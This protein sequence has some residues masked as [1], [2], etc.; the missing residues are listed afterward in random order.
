MSKGGDAPTPPDPAKTIAAQTQSNQQ[1][2][3]YQQ[4]LNFVNSNT[5]LGSLKYTKLSD[6]SDGTPPQW[7]SDVSLTDQG[8]QA[9]D[10]NQAVANALSRLALQGT[11]Q[12]S[13][14]IARPAGYDSL[15]K[16]PEGLDLSGLP[17]LASGL[18]TRGLP[19]LATGLDY[20][21]LPNAPGG[22]DLSALGDAPKFDINSGKAASDALY[23]QATSRL[24]PQYAKA[25]AAME[26]K[27]INSGLSK[28]TPAYNSAWESYNRSK[29]DAY[30]SASREATAGGANY[31][32]QLLGGQLAVRGQGVSE[33]QQ[34]LA[35]ALSLRQNAASEAQQKFSAT[36][37]SRA[38]GFGEAL[39]GFNAQ[40]SARAQG[41]GERQQSLADALQLRQQGVTESNYLRELP[42]NEV[43]ALE[44]GGQVQLPSFG[45]PAPVSVGR[46]D[47][48]GITQQ[49][50]QNQQTQYQQQQAQQQAL[51]GDVFG[52]AGAA[53]GGWGFGG[54]K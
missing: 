38:Q 22:L 20:S 12:V 28:G 8:Q 27:L 47:V 23:A 44:S 11:S 16:L 35:D 19:A 33:A 43:T 40:N 1:T 13:D 48:A 42:L 37:S 30:G 34:K 31:A 2:A 3:A 52:L 49:G 9:F 53:A 26:T 50:F 32:T 54:F 29:N 10:Q 46:T 41:V 51:L 14:A 24:D 5:P 25:D 18:S 39:Q 21:N 36:N 45:A 17:E 15:G 6:G 7:Q 4:Q